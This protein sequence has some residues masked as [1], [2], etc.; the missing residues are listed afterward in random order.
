MTTVNNS[1]DLTFIKELI[2]SGK[3]K[4]VIDKGYPLNEVQDAFRY[5]GTKRAKGKVYFQS[6]TRIAPHDNIYKLKIIL[7]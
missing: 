5:L 4:P 6:I 1:E 7:F 2:E 3:V